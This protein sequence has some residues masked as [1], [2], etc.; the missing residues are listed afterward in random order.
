MY[1]TIKEYLEENLKLKMNIEGP[2]YGMSGINTIQLLLE[3]EVISEIH[4]DRSDADDE[5]R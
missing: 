1:D 5:Y 4:W 2:R 3:D